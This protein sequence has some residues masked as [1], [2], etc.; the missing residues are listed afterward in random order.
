MVGAGLN[1]A[2]KASR[3]ISNALSGGDDDAADAHSMEPEPRSMNHAARSR[4]LL[5]LAS[6]NAPSVMPR[7]G[8]FQIT[9]RQ[10][11]TDYRVLLKPRTIEFVDTPSSTLSPEQNR[12]AHNLV[13]AT[14]RMAT[15]LEAAATAQQRLTAA[16]TARDQE[17]QDKQGR[18]LLYSKRAAGIEMVHVAEALRALG[19]STRQAPQVTE[20]NVRDGQQR[21]RNGGFPA[22]VV[23]VSR[24]LGLSDAEL[25]A[26]RQRLL[27][28]D[29]Q[30]TAFAVRLTIQGLQDAL[31]RYGAYLAL[32]PEI[33]APW[34]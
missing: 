17:W 19:E 30:Q 3:Q 20:A 7:P 31:Y 4:S 22:A 24:Q 28:Q 2:F 29:P 33:E 21:L 12:L 6:W 10:N 32:L 16:V 18:A 26:S 15:A 25:E 1:S 11:V 27:A 13:A 8:V 34:N 14:F 9:R 23:D 5:T